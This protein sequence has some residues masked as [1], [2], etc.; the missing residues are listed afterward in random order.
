MHP[1]KNVKFNKSLKKILVWTD[2][3][4]QLL[5]ESKTQ[6]VCGTTLFE[7]I[8]SCF[9]L[10]HIS[11]FLRQMQNDFLVLP[12]LQTSPADNHS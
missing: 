8:T 11:I 3:E 2:D 4:V 6:K 5:L 10:K 9:F 1:K 12:K 7:P